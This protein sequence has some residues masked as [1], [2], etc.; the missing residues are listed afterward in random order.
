MNHLIIGYGQ[1]GKGIEGA[2]RENKKN[3]IDTSEEERNYNF[4][5]V[6]FGWQSGFIKQVQK[7]VYDHPT[8]IVIVHSTV[9]VGTMEKIGRYAV[10]HSPVRGKHP[11]LTGGILTFTKYF[12]GH[13]SA[14]KQAVQPFE[15][16]GINCVQTGNYRNT[17]LGKLLDT[18]YYGWNILFM[19]EVDKICK[20]LGADFDLIYRDFN[21][22]YNEGYTKLGQSNVVRPVLVPVKGKIGGHCVIPN[23]EIL[24]N[25]FDPAKKILKGDK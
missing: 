13:C 10:V 3:I 25:D 22:S 18:T 15:E 1:V 20:K 6:C 12:S 2:L 23:C 8:S 9:P 7:L 21:E 4:I 11:N 5:H 16:I 19:K 17:E 24:K 14:T